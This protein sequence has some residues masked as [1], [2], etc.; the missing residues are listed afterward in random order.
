MRQYAS[1]KC[2]YL[3]RYGIS[4]VIP[5]I[6]GEEFLKWGVLPKALSFFAR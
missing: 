3:T 2:G 5:A 4:A 1:L 6:Y